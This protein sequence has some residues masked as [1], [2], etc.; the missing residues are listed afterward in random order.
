MTNK[1]ILSFIQN[2]ESRDKHVDLVVV[3]I[4]EEVLALLVTSEKADFQNWASKGST[5]W[6]VL[7]SGG[8][9][10]STVS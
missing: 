7:I 10:P 6:T 1:Y 9:S 2:L 4:L 5:G 3:A 8:N